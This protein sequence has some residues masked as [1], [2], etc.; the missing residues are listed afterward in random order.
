ML[1]AQQIKT[2]LTMAASNHLRKSNRVT[3]LEL[4]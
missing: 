1:S 2:L 3:A 4:A